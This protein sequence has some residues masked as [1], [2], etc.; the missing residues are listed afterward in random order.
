MQI[1]YTKCD[2]CKKSSTPNWIRIKSQEDD[3]DIIHT[4]DLCEDCAILV[5]EQLDRIKEEE[6]L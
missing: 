1:T 2:C 3:N 6:S 4:L 5:T